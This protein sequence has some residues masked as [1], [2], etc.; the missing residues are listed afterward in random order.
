MWKKL[1]CVLLLG[2]A[3]SAWAGPKDAVVS[4]VWVGESIPGQ[5]SATLELNITT[6]MPARLISVSTEVADKVEI[7]SVFQNRGKM[8]AHVV[9]SLPLPAHRTTAFG[10]HKLFLML[11]GLKRELNIDDQIS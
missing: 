8:N 2:L 3:G 9:D 11:V 7:H 6:V 5:G 4:H 1:L 10:S